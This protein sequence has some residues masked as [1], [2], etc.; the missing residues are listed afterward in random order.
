MFREIEKLKAR[1]RELQ[2]EL[3]AYKS[4]AIDTKP[5]SAI[6]TPTESSVGSATSPSSSRSQ[7]KNSTHQASS[8]SPVPT[9]GKS[10]SKPQWQGI[11]LATSRT[12]QSSYYGP[13]SHFF[14]VS[15]IGAYLNK[16]LGKPC[17]PRSM[18][19]QEARRNAAITNPAEDES[20]DQAS[21]ATGG[22]AQSPGMSRQQEE[23][24]LSLFWESYHCF[25]PIV[26]EV[27][28]RRHYSSLWE[29]GKLYRRPSPIVDIV[30]ALCL[31]Y[32]FT[33]M[34]RD[35]NAPDASFDDA[36]MAGRYYYRRC[37]SLMTA[38]LESPT[39]MT[40][41]CHIFSIAYLCCASFHNMAHLGEATAIR[42]AQILGLHLEPPSDLPKGERELRKRI[43]WTLWTIEAKTTAKLGRPCGVDRSQVTVTL[44]SDDIE[45]A[46]ANGATLGSYGNVTWL[47]Y[48]IEM[49]K[50]IDVSFD[51]HYALYTKCGQALD[52]AGQTSLYK[53]SQA[54]ESCAELLAARCPALKTWA[55]AVPSSMKT[56]R[57]QGGEPFS[58]DRTPL[59]VDMLA[60]TWLSR[61]RICLELMYHTQ[62]VNLG[63]PFIAFYSNSN[64][65]TPIAERHATACVNHAIAHTLIMHQVVTETD[66]MGGWSEYFFWQWNA[67]ITITGFILAYPIHSSTPNARRALE[68]GIAIF[69]AFG[70]NFTVAADAAKIIRDLLTKADL[71]AG[72]LRNGVT[73][74]SPPEPHSA[75][76]ANMDGGQAMG[77]NGMPQG[78]DGLAW[79]NP[80]EQNDPNYFSEFMDWALSVDQFNSFERFFDTQNPADPFQF[81][82]QGQ[83]G[84]PGI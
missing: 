14:F 32:G 9:A 40:V 48:S 11:Y 1:V 2:T 17:A 53:D 13:S 61:Q 25:L 62:M 79:L 71:L 73:S 41:Q 15:R 20:P 19:P 10:V 72:R 57:R 70:T 8:Q 36:T 84:Q 39:I 47:T 49:H 56:P 44:P 33:F 50:L 46:S 74:Q 34:P 23:Y 43:W 12:D 76:L 75:Q 66:L 31:Q 16:A 26:D 83:F 60:P 54:L 58:I 68:K 29:P 65:Y 4:N 80:T 7:R 55:E 69:D 64:T 38:D 82:Q 45:A 24:F 63:R 81:G 28:F 37:Q 30:L 52:A 21:L 35:V 27:E 18:Q 77:F 51:I 78:D 6:P 22:S 42:T 67:A 3:N 59:D 5:G